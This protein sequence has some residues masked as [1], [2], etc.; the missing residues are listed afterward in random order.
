MAF[1]IIFLRILKPQIKFLLTFIKKKSKN[2]QKESKY[3]ENYDIACILVITYN[4]NQNC[5]GKK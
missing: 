2:S 1:C 5:F 4:K 3:F